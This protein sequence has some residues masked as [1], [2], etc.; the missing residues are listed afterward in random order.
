MMTV[1]D[2]YILRSLLFNYVV[3]LGTMLSLYVVLD[4]FAVSGTVG[5]VA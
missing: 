1:L 3:A 4:M 5:V 2:R